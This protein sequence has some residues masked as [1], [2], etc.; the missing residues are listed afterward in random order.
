MRGRKRRDP[1]EF[2]KVRP[3]YEE[4]AKS[5]KKKI[6]PAVHVI[7]SAAEVDEALEKKDTT[8]GTAG[9]AAETTKGTA[10]GAADMA[11]ESVAYVKDTGAKGLGS[12]LVGVKANFASKVEVLHQNV[13]LWWCCSSTWGD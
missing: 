6:G 1:E 3:N 11:K 7:K 12:K 10:A 8:Y 4:A 5:F 2:E 9:S 13:L